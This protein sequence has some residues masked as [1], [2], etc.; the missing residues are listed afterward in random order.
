MTI[1]RPEF[2]SGCNL[3]PMIS[4]PTRGRRSRLEALDGLRGVVI[5]LVV[6]GHLSAFL[7]PVDGVRSTPFLRGLVGGGAVAAFYVISGFIVTNGLLGDQDRQQLDPARFLARRVVRVGTQVA[8]LCVALLVVRGV[9]ATDTNSWSTTITSVTHTL[10][11]TINWL[12]LTAPASTRPDMGHLWFVAIQQQWYLVLPLLLVVLGHRRRWIGAILVVGAAACAVYRLVTVADDTWFRMSVDTFARA[13]ALMLGMALAVF[14]PLLTRLSGRTGFVAGAALALMF[15][16]LA[17]N[18]EFGSIA[19]L[20]PWSIAFNLASLI[21]VA[22]LILTPDGVL[23]TNAL[24]WSPLAWLGR[25]SLVIY[26]WHYPLIFWVGRHVE[27]NGTPQTLVVLAMLA[28]IS[29]VCHRWIEEPVRRWL[30]THL[31]PPS[32]PEPGEP[33]P[34]TGDSTTSPEVSR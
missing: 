18:R 5:I 31:R 1:R 8:V 12:L 24:T 30:S 26:V 20:G 23:V 13:D 29:V 16:L 14:L 6:L 27:G 19:F 21:L 28:V 25:T 11:Y 32:H 33:T 4:N 7:W 34:P 15:V 22:A 9:D 3:H 10:T 2:N 17:V